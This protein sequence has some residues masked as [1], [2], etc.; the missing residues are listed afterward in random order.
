MAFDKITPLAAPPGHSLTD[1]PGKWAWERPPQYADPDQ[2]LDFVLDALE[3]PMRQ[4]DMVR[5][6]AAGVSIEELVSQIAFKGFMS[7]FYTPDVA[8]LMKP[9]IAIYLYHAGLEA[10]F[11]PRMMF[12][13]EDEDGKEEGEVSD[14][15][16]LKIM[17]QRNPKLY[18]R[19][20]EEINRQERM[21]I[22]ATIKKDV[23]TPVEKQPQSFL[24]MGE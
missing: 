19:M 23:P 2:A 9:S 4:Q 8:E 10:G 12:S 3:D 13:Q 6:M 11:E 14:V 17:K 20:N 15:A 21:Q 18:E 1:E 5:M 24:A 16:F 22:E 7:G